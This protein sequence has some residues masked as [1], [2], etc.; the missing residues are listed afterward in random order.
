MQLL[1]EFDKIFPNEEQKSPIEYLKGGSREAILRA[2]TFFSG[3]EA[4]KSQFDDIKTF[5]EMFF[6]E[7]NKNFANEVYARVKQLQADGNEVRFFNPFSSLK[8]FEDF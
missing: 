3:L 6:S 2:A 8:L 7:P 1:L 4:N 5:L